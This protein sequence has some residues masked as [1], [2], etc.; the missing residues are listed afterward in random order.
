MA[1]SKLEHMRVTYNQHQMR[2]LPSNSS[3]EASSFEDF[4]KI[5]I[6]AQNWPGVGPFGP[7]RTFH[8]I[9]N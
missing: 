9:L 7:Y 5:H 6:F 8:D 2:L 3:L 1:F 4:V